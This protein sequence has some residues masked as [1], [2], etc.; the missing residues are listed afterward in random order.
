MYTSQSR[1]AASSQGDVA[2]WSFRT[3]V[4]DSLAEF[5]QHEMEQEN[6]FQAPAG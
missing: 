4:R 6:T 1:E 2:G 5:I 3:Q